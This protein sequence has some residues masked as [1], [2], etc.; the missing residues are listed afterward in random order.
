MP[1]TKTKSAAKVKTPAQGTAAKKTSPTRK[2]APALSRTM[3]AAAEKEPK[4]Q[5][6][7]RDSFTMPKSEFERIAELKQQCLSA[8]M[9]VKKSELLRAGLRALTRLK[10]AELVRAI[11]A[12]DAVKTGRPLSSSANVPV[13]TSKKRKKAK[14]K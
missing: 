1:Q 10:P 8:G 2:S 12:L 14:I 11:N 5:K 13:K 9:A 6:V 7:V 3:H 4:K